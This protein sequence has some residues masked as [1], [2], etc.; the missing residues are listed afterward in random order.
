MDSLSNR[1]KKIPLQVR[2]SV[3]FLVCSFMQKA[4]SAITT[5]IFT[6]LLS[7]S[8]YG[9]FSVYF[10]WQSILSV[11]MSLNLFYGVY[12]SGL[13]KFKERKNEFISSMQGLT[14][15]LLMGWAVVYFIFTEQINHILSFTTIQTICL[16]VSVWANA[17]F[18]FWS[19]EQRVVY[20]Y[21]KLVCV[22]IVVSFLK[23]AIGIAAVVL[24]KDKVTA[25]VVELALVEFCCFSWMFVCHIK[26]CRKLYSAFFWKYALKFNIPLIPHYLAQNILGSADRIMID[27]MVSSDAAG[28]YSLAYSVSLIMTLFN[29]ALTQ[30]VGPWVYE[31]IRAH[32]E[33]D[34]RKIVM[35]TIIIIAGLNLLLIAFAPEVVSIFAP[36]EYYE[37]IWTIPPVVMSVYYIYLYNIFSY[38]EFYYEKTKLI[39]LATVVAAVVNIGLNYVF[40]GCFGYI[41]A[42]YTTLVCYILYALGHY[43]VMKSVAETYCAGEQIVLGKNVTIVSIVFM[44]LGFAFTLLYRNAGARYGLVFGLM[45]LV[46]LFRKTIIENIKSVIGVRKSNNEESK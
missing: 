12:T 5:P 34:I 18:S 31:Q 39:A 4:I 46:V 1:Y 20:Q 32:H 15:T 22:T 45:V 2:A 36:K 17:V 42:G 14:F 24:C 6:R 8:E 38:Y 40:I 43:I 30:T 33:K 44:M 19:G 25:R 27:R 11:F 29:T 23:P 21:K 7:N 26:R 37:A 16:F 35:P 28:I 3:W 10:S 9:Q 13:V 41:A